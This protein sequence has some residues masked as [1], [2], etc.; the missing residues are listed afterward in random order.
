MPQSAGSLDI[1][2]LNSFRSKEAYLRRE[3]GR[4]V[5]IDVNR[6]CMWMYI[7]DVGIYTDYKEHTKHNINPV[8]KSHLLGWYLMFRSWPFSVDGFLDC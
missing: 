5:Q 1:P 2:N 7:I 6:K 8:N 4:L 3:I